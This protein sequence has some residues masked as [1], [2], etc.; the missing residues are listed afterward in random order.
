MRQLGGA[1]LD[2]L[3]VPAQPA[4]DQR[5]VAERVEMG[6]EAAAL[7]DVADLPADG[8]QLRAGEGAAA[9]ADLACVRPDEAVEEPQQRRFAGAAR[10]DQRRGAAAGDGEVQRAERERVVVALDGADGLESGLAHL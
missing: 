3:L 9:E 7:H 5:D 8:G 10:T 2:P 1:R 4:R 6:E